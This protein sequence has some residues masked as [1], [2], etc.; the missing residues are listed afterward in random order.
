MKNR[1]SQR[2]VWDIDWNLLRTFMV[3]VQEKGITSAGEKLR[4]K[5]PTISNALRRLEGHFDCRL[6]ERRPGVF[7]VTPAGQRLYAECVTLFDSVSGLHTLVHDQPD[8]VTGQIDMA[9]ASH[10]VCPFLDD[11]L[12]EFHREHPRVTF[13]TSVLPS[14]EV[15]AN[16]TRKDA[17]L[18]VCLLHERH[19]K[20]EFRTLYRESFGYFCG[21]QHRLFG[22]KDLSIV[23]LRDEPYVSFKTDQMADALWPIAMLRQQEKFTGPIIG[24][25]SHLE[26]VKR[27]LIA[28]FGFGPLPIHVVEEDVRKGLLWR[29]PPYENPPEIDVHL[30][31]DPQARHTRAE[32]LLLE[33][34][35]TRIEETPLSERTYP[36]S[37]A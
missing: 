30:A 28:G 4:L 24:T 13:A 34:L 17:A 23:D 1:R 29:L 19:P 15:I 8:E 6:I 26:E 10:V 18:G 36:I 5:Q 7:E 14:Q 32:A 37:G 27:L 9:F 2:F 20:L 12:A 35:L 3:I 16:V 21:R 25:S 22:R 11:I 33:K 31:Y